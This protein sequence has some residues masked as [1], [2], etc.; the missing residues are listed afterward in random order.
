MESLQQ[1]LNTLAG[2]Q[3]L[4]VQA[5]AN[6]LAGTNG[7][8]IQSA[9]NTYAGTANLS[10]QGALNAKAGT[11]GLSAFDAA[12]AI[13][14]GP[15]LIDSYSETNADAVSGTDTD[16]LHSGGTTG[17]TESFVGVAKKITSCKFFL[18]RGTNSITGNATATLHWATN[19]GDGWYVDSAALATS[20]N[21]DVSTLTTTRQLV[22]FTFSGA[23]Q[24]QME[25]AV[26]YCIAVNYTGGDATHYVTIGLDSSGP[27]HS[28]NN[29]SYYNTGV[30]AADGTIST[31][32]YVYGQ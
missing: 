19:E 3:N 1:R 28:D 11:N 7:K 29:M 9:L 32:F 26:R 31:C 4:S 2:T 16:R 5:A 6:S 22:E 21:V 12:N 8:S 20:G 14:A 30:W 23:Q 10:I 24:Y 13:T 25:S 27:T 17:F 18:G 15:S